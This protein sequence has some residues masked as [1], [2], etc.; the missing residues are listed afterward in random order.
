MVAKVKRIRTTVLH[1]CLPLVLFLVHL[2]IQ[3]FVRSFVF[4]FAFGINLCCHCIINSSSTNQMRYVRAIQSLFLIFYLDLDLKD[5]RNHK[6]SITN[7]QN[8]TM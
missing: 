5:M 1:A 7:T 6:N 3:W 8:A 2:F 4:L